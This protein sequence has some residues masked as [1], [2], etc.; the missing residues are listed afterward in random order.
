[1]KYPF[2]VTKIISVNKSQLSTCRVTSP[3][4]H[5]YFKT[6]KIIDVTVLN[7][8]YIVYYRGRN[9]NLKSNPLFKVSSPPLPLSSPSYPPPFPSLLHPPPSSPFPGKRTMVPLA[10]KIL[11]FQV[12][13]LL[14]NASPEI[15]L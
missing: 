15:S 2:E 7:V 14:E 11:K 12:S 4:F 10:G 8:W 3:Y 13:R 9:K 6:A 5:Y 1:M